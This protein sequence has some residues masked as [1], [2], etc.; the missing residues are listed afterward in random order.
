[1]VDKVLYKSNFERILHLSYG[2]EPYI[3]DLIYI[4]VETLLRI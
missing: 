3:Y 2:K 4:T 1:M